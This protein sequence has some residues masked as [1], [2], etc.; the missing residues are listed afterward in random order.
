MWFILRSKS[1]HTKPGITIFKAPCYER[2]FTLTSLGFTSLVLSRFL[3]SCTFDQ[4]IDYLPSLMEGEG[5]G[6]KSRGVVSIKGRK[7]SRVTAVRGSVRSVRMR[8]ELCMNDKTWG[9]KSGYKDISL[10]TH[11]GLWLCNTQQY[12]R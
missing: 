6:R 9:N 4:V 7:G 5:T 10:C 12:D 2:L 8:R 3:I 1:L 11:R